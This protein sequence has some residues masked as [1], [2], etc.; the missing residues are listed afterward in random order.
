MPRIPEKIT[1][2]SGRQMPAILFGTGTAFFNKGAEKEDSE[3]ILSLH[4]A[5]K[6]AI[7]LGYQGIDTA[8]MYNNE[9]FVGQ[10]LSEFDPEQKLWVTTKVSPQNTGE[11]RNHLELSLKKLNR[12]SVDLYLIHFPWIEDQVTIQ[13]AWKQMEELKDAGLAKDI[14]VSNFQVK[15]IL[16]ILEVAKH[17]PVVNQIEY[18]VQLQQPELVELC[19]ENG[20]LIQSY[21]PQVP[22]T[23]GKT[24]DV[25]DCL[26]D[27][28]EKYKKT[29]G[30]VLLKY[31]NQKGFIIATTSTKTSRLSESLEI[32]DFDITP[33]EM[34]QLSELGASHRFRKFKLDLPTV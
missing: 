26:T 23:T 16:K 9:E 28:A 10:A 30:Q 13:S 5:I 29:V 12:E 33:E 21:G 27:L 32:G 24:R 11:I 2:S 25:L 18:H 14:G 15:D 17:K 34:E 4:N 8:E 20:I 3:N 6:I 19:T 31:V 22:V 1:I 7:E